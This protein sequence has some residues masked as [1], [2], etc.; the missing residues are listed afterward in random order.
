MAIFTE[1]VL[2][3]MTLTK[4]TM[5]WMNRRSLRRLLV[6]V[7]NNFIVDNYNTIE[8]RFIFMKYTK[9]AK[10]YFLV[11]VPT[12]T[13]AGAFYY[14]QELMPNVRM[15]ITNSSLSYKLPY[16]TR[17]IID[18][19]DIRIYI[20]LCIYQM[21]VIPCITLGFVGFDC[22]FTNLAFHITAQFGILSCTIREILDDSN[23]FQCNIRKLV[24]QHYK[25][26]S[27]NYNLFTKVQAES[28][29]NNFNVIILQQLMGTTLQLCISGY[30]TL[31]STVSKEG[32][33]L[34][35]F[36]SYAFGVLSTLFTY[37]YIGEC[38]IQES[39]N[40]SNA[41]YRYE[42]YNVSPMNLKM[43]NICM[44]RMKK[45]QQLTSGKFFVLSLASFTDI[46]KTTMGYLS[47]L[48]TLL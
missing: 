17:T 26:I 12:M 22:L 40:L 3:L 10:Y 20:C 47:V 42:W 33:T 14:I 31:L 27:G 25:L 7:Q 18:I 37:C 35:L 4:I 29:E 34:I 24:F 28:L 8:K 44:L 30:N 43:V 23:G 41:F 21:L 36:Y 11:A 39:S 6:E 38:L 46:L 32:I 9:L 1:N 13:I 16:K 5:C 45:P 15:A 19:R 2:L 48:R